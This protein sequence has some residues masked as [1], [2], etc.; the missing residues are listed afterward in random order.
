MNLLL[1]KGS[2][3]NGC[4]EITSI[5]NCPMQFVFTA[6]NNPKGLL[7]YFHSLLILTAQLDSKGTRDLQAGNN[8]VII[9][10]H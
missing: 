7:S 10:L 2:M 8:W 3:S 9:R 5:S 4:K 6:I 1:G